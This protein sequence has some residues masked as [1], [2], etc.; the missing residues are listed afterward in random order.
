MQRKYSALTGVGVAL[1]S[2]ED[3]LLL[4]TM[5]TSPLLKD[6]HDVFQVSCRLSTYSNGGLEELRYTQANPVSRLDFALCLVLKAGH[7]ARTFYARRPCTATSLL[8]RAYKHRPMCSS[9]TGNC[10]YSPPATGVDLCRLKQAMTSSPDGRGVFLSP[11]T[12]GRLGA[13]LCPPF[14]YPH[15]PDVCLPADMPLH[16][17]EPP[18]PSQ[19]QEAKGPRRMEA[20]R[21]QGQRGNYRRS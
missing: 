13:R 1:Q 17:F 2:D 8:A 14:G 12:L 19:T 21:K 5:I 15:H 6:E 16:S 3:L 18:S 20:V 4:E 11:L 7:R 9:R 10:P